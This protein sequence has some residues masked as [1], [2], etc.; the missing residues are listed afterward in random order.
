MAKREVGDSP[1]TIAFTANGRTAYVVNYASITVTPIRTATN[2]TLK[3]IK[4][5][6]GPV[7]ITP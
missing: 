3:P 4:I 2:I 5:G 7:A 1:M 6:T